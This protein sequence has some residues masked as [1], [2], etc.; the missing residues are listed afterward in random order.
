MNSEGDVFVQSSLGL[1][2]FWK[3]TD[4]CHTKHMASGKNL[5]ILL[6]NRQIQKYVA[7]HNKAG[8][9]TKV[10]MKTGTVPGILYSIQIL[11]R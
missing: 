3:F 9:K 10:K 6:P 7:N 11:S 5:G 4:V 2:H 1:V 8:P